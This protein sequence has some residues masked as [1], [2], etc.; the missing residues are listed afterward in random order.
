MVVESTGGVDCL[1]LVVPGLRLT[2]YR[3][4]FYPFLAVMSLSL[5]QMTFSPCHVIP[6]T[7]ESD[8]AWKEKK[9]VKRQK[10]SDGRET[11]V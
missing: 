2:L 9:R 6:G 4:F 10:K 5:P 3:P 8:T 1:T 11:N 7:Q